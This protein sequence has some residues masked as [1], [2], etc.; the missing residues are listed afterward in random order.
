MSSPPEFPA[1]IEL[2]VLPLRSVV[3]F[4]HAALPITVSR[5]S[6]V[7]AIEAVGENGFIAVVT[8]LDPGEDRPGA[9][10]LYQI[11]TG[12]VVRQM[13]HLG[14]DRDAAMLVMEG[15][16]R[17]AV[18]EELQ[19]EPYPRIRVRRLASE[20]RTADQAV[21]SALRR[22]VLDL[23]QDVVRNSPNLP[24]D[25]IVLARNIADD[26]ALTDVIASALVDVPVAA[27]QSLLATLDVR[28]RLER[29]TEILVRERE[30][31]RI[32]ESIRNQV[33]QKIAGTQREYVLREQLKAIRQELGDEKGEEQE[34]E[35][36]SL[37]L[38]S[39]PIPHEARKEADREL[40]R[41]RHMPPGSPESSVVR[42][43]LDWL[44][45]LP[46]G[47]TSGSLAD[48]DHSAAI[49]DE[50]HYDLAKI[51][52]RILEYLAVQRLKQELRGPIL[53]FVG[54]PGVGKTSL[55]RSIARATGREFVRLSLGGVH[56]EAEIRGHR[57]T[58][59]GAMPGQIIRSLRRAGTCDPIF[60]LDE[61]DKLGKDFRGDP[62]AAL[63]E[64]LD[65]EQNSSFRDHYLDVPFDLSRVFFVTTANTI[66]PIPAALRDRMEII[67]LSGYIDE[68]K[69]QIAERYLIPK[70]VDAHGLTRDQHLRFTEEAILDV[71]RSHT[72]EA[73]VRK[74]E[75]H[76]AAICRKRARQVVRNDT[77]LLTITPTVVH[78]MLG[79][80]RYH[81]E[82]QLE[83]RT[84]RPG[85]A[86]AVAWTPCGG[87]VL[88]VETTRIPEG[89]GNFTLTGQLGDVM[90]ESA[91]TALSWVRA[92]AARYQ[93]D[94]GAFR[95]HDLHVHVPGGA[96]PKDGPS[97][98]IVIVTALI[99]RLTERPIRP[100]VAMTGEITLSGVLLPIGG[101]KEKVLAA[102]RSGVRELVLPSEN[103]PNLRDEVPPH[104]HDGL[105]IHFASTIEHAIDIA[106]DKPLNGA[107]V[108]EDAE[109]WH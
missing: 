90:Q 41:L 70:Q 62:S 69:L 56:D 22:N 67:E 94:E 52:E 42:T 38:D 108:T 106:L 104:L 33:T 102:R 16:E 98:G 37:Q 43:Y 5:R 93:I 46:W 26:G 100:F 17:I 60:M 15:V 58:Y 21:E 25:L 55:G 3:L 19:L 77:S 23:F 61:I 48:L 75:Q 53:C 35:D 64:A 95:R 36:L 20:K 28:R 91:R 45:Q 27:R 51:K 47:K 32:G 97:A 9:S 1:E 44:A 109:R 40:R 79:P 81:I 107:A 74:L 66:D 24:D 85:V 30:S 72:H 14:E 68:E 39:A 10:E 7:R 63:L 87:E 54:P 50:D 8:Q 4:P 84:R 89:K 13:T 6:A 49:L 65:P 99:S 88:F 101:I 11:G 73:G 80:A 76:I 31:L 59:V 86:V 83:E 96:V 18:I 2:P 57:R 105:T 34:L 29:L 78:D 92:N 82:S 71:I 12:A 103:E